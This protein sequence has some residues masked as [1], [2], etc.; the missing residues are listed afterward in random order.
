MWMADSI[1]S[2]PDEL[3]KA[4]ARS[5]GAISR[6]SAARSAMGSLPNEKRYVNVSSST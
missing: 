6:T 4:H 1:D 5:I 3:K 2:E